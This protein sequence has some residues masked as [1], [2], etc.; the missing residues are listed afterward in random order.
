VTADPVL[1]VAGS[2]S[3]ASG[4]ASV[5]V[6]GEESSGPTAPFSS[7]VAL[8]N[9]D[10]S[11]EVIAKDAGGNRSTRTVNVTFDATAPPLTVSTPADNSVTFTPF[12][13]LAGSAAPGS[14]VTVTVNDAAGES[15]SVT[16]GRFTGSGLLLNGVN[17]IEV[18]ASLAGRVSKIKRTVI[19]AHGKP[20]VAISEPAEDIRS[21]QGSV[22]IR[23]TAGADGGDVALVLEVNESTLSPQLQSGTF[24]QEVTLSGGKT[25]ILARVTDGSGNVS[26]AQRNIIKVEKIRGDTNG[27]GVVD[28]RDAM[29]LLRMSLGLDPVTPEALAH[30]DLAPLVNGV[31]Q[32]DG[33]IDV[34]D[35]MILLRRIVGLVEF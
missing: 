18:S 33:R 29:L 34:E 8:A 25:R 4:I 7:A 20:A 26:I 5:T 13:T 22:T 30:S 15:L 21:E 6:K 9:G 31:P 1:N 24:Q 23:G 12:F 3:D 32:P 17:T 2:A 14:A 16:E 35:V 27:D 19:L 28:L 11:I 10:N